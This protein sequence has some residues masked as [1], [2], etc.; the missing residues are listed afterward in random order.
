MKSFQHKT[1]GC[2]EPT[3]WYGQLCWKTEIEL[4]A[5]SAFKYCRNGRAR[6]SKKV[7]V[8]IFCDSEPPKAAIQ[9]LIKIRKS[10]KKLVDNIC[11]AFF[12]DLHQDG[13]HSETV[14]HSKFGMWWSEDPVEVAMSCREALEK[15]L[16]RDRL[17]QPEDVLAILYEPF[18]AIYP[19]ETGDETLPRTLINMGAEFEDEHGVSVLTDGIKVLNLGYMGEA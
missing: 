1:L 19:S 2:F 15:R 12:D 6:R 9:M 4:T 16:K 11:K 5:F 8:S 7:H 14:P 18:I 3:D 10:Q 17:W 13:Y